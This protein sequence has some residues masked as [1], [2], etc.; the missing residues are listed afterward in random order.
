MRR[1]GSD[2]GY[3]TLQPQ[4][5]LRRKLSETGQSRCHVFSVLSGPNRSGPALYEL[6]PQRL[7]SF[8]KVYDI[9]H[10][11][12]HGDLSRRLND[13]LT[14]DLHLQST[15]RIRHELQCLTGSTSEL[16]ITAVKNCGP[17]VDVHG[18]LSSRLMFESFR[19]T[20]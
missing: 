18:A 12:G 10:D 5:K 16:K 3:L 7:V 1:S 20:Q 11:C 15:T 8:E 19:N 2:G 13:C 6:L 4:L 14:Y 9:R 17:T